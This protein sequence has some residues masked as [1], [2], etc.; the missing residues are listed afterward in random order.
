MLKYFFVLLFI[1]SNVSFASEAQAS[2][3]TDINKKEQQTD[4]NLT[5]I[6]IERYKDELME[7]QRLQ[8]ENL[9]LKLRLENR[10]L[11]KSLGVEP[12]RAEGVKLIAV[13][14]SGAGKLRAKI[15]EN[16]L[17]NVDEGDVLS[18]KYEVIKINKDNIKIKD[19]SSME[20]D[21]IF[22]LSKG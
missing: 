21:T 3:H 7:Y 10:T 16:G 13:M 2:L 22:L 4:N 1:F 19:L 14:S 20:E 9:M 17:K 15:Y 8:R 18:D 5:E 6:N 12:F 11:E